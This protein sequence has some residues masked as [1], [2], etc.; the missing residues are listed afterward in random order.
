LRPLESEKF[1]ST[2][3]KTRHYN[4]RAEAA[5]Y[6]YGGHYNDH[7]SDQGGGLRV[8]KSDARVAATR[9]ARQMT[10]ATPY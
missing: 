5:S 4:C 8:W 9:E 7:Y 6:N 2:G 10:R 1:K 3:L